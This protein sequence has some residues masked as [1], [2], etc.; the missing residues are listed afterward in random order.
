M[1]VK[2]IH[3][4]PLWVCATAIRKCWASENKSDIKTTTYQVINTK[5]SIA[6]IKNISIKESGTEDK[7]LIE[8]VGNKN[9]HGSVLEHLVYSFDISGVTRA[10]LQELVRHR[11]AS[12]S[13][14]SSRYTLKELKKETTFKSEAGKKRASEY[15]KMSGNDKVDCSLIASLEN[16]RVRIHEG[17]SNDLAKY[18]IPEAYKTSLVWT[19]NMRSLQNFVRL[20]SSPSALKEIQKL[21]KKVCDALPSEHSYLIKDSIYKKK[22]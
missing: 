4:T 17:V 12:I 22:D 13:V 19:I 1:K 11:H 8:K 18:C 16:L 7:K 5:S 10:L 6:N 20:R 9:K 3:Y 21:A 2:L 14:K 15:I